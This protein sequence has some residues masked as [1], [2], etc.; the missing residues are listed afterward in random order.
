MPKV[1]SVEPASMRV[2]VVVGTPAF[3]A[4]ARGGEPCVATGIAKQRDR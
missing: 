1:G 2:T 4:R 3:A